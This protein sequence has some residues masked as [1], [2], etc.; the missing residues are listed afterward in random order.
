MVG[1]PERSSSVR[2]VARAE[3]RGVGWTVVEYFRQHTYTLCIK[4]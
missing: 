3:T 2:A 1:V 4:V